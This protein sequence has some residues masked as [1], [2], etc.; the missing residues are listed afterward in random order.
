MKTFKM[1]RGADFSSC[2]GTGLILSGVIFPES[3]KTVVAWNSASKVHSLGIYDSY[4]DF[5]RVHV[6]SHENNHTLIEFSDNI[7][8]ENH[9]R[10]KTCRH[11]KNLLSEHPR[12]NQDSTDNYRRTCFG[13]LVKIK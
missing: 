6:A 2:S 11:C 9:K 13:D 1:Y 8:V 10:R 7:Q 12:D 5:Y 4:F 3:G